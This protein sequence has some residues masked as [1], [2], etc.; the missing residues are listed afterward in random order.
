L[1]R[2]EGFDVEIQ[3]KKKLFFEELILIEAKLL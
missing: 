2:N 1:T 3:A